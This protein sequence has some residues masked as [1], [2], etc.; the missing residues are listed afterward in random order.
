MTERER[1]AWIDE[2]GESVLADYIVVHC[3]NCEYWTALTISGDYTPK[4]LCTVGH[5]SRITQEV[6]DE[7]SISRKRIPIY[8]DADSSCELFAPSDDAIDDAVSDWQNEQAIRETEADIRVE[9]QP[10]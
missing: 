8:T 7:L 5:C 2:I 3:E 1:A 6:F 9:R 4:M 10:L